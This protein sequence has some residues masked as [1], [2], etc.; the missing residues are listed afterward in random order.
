MADTKPE[1]NEVEVEEKTEFRYRHDW[2]C[3]FVQ[4]CFHNSSVTKFKT[5][6]ILKGICYFYYSQLFPG[7]HIAVTGRPYYHH[8]IFICAEYCIVDYGGENK[9][10]A[11]KNLWGE[12]RLVRINYPNRK[13][14][15]VIKT[16]KRLKENPNEWGEYNLFKNNCEHFATYCK[17]E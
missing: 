15:D 17:L 3:I 12:K 16:A 1:N 9:K 11:T 2:Q 4:F 10:D 6:D 14:I 5:S 13:P 7:N 8:S